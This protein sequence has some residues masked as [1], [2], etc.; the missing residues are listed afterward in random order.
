MLLF[1]SAVPSAGRTSGPRAVLMETAPFLY[2][3]L[4][5]VLIGCHDSVAEK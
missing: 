1:V 4:R 2:D 5:A 3:H